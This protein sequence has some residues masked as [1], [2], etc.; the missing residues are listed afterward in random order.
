MIFNS[1]SHMHLQEQL[2]PLLILGYFHT[3]PCRLPRHHKM[4]ESKSG[5]LEQKE[6]I[7]LEISL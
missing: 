6:K 4:Y 7:P 2:Q 5:L 1:L 3:I